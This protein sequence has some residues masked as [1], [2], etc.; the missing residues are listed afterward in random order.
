M[1]PYLLLLK[2]ERKKL[3]ETL[4][5]LR[6]LPKEPSSGIDLE[7]TMNIF[8]TWDIAVWFNS[9]SSEHAINFI[10]NKLSQIAGVVDTFPVATFPHLGAT[11]ESAKETM[12]TS[13]ES[14]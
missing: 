8:G 2:L 9:D 6:A 10:N 7:Y 12:E 3:L 11:K 14:T 13:E 1:P 5:T 4:N